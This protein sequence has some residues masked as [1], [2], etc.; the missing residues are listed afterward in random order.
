MIRLVLAT[1]LSSLLLVGCGA[2]AKPTAST[3]TGRSPAASA[4]PTALYFTDAESAAINA[5]AGPAQAAGA[6]ALTGKNRDHC[7][8]VGRTQGL[9]PWQRCWHALLDPMSKSL[10]DLAGEL[11]E[12]QGRDFP[13]A[14]VTELAQDEQVFTQQRARVQGLLGG[15][16]SERRAAQ[17]R[18]MKTYDAT[19]RA[20]L[21][22]FT[23][24]FHDFTQ[25]CY[26]PE[27]L[28]KLKASATPSASPTS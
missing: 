3:S 10:A 12:L 22:S 24:P 19:L 1:A 9:P 11:H 14:C 15:I 6:Q 18:S 7:D 16:D 2:E 4:S 13:D 26:S 21:S 23:K 27:V 20:A 5:S 25:A 8:K 28:A 17:A